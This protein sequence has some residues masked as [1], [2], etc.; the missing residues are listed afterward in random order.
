MTKCEIC[1][2]ET[3]LSPIHCLNCYQETDSK[4]MAEIQLLDAFNFVELEVDLRGGCK[5]RIKKKDGKLIL[6]VWAEVQNGM[7]DNQREQ[8]DEIPVKIKLWKK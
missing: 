5:G 7:D 6:E 4:E 2:K 3:V 8:A 1:G